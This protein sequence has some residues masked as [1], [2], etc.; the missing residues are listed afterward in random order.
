MAIWDRHEPLTV[1]GAAA[2]LH[3][4]PEHLRLK[5]RLQQYSPDG[6]CHDGCKTH[7]QEAKVFWFFFSKKN[8][9]LTK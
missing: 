5:E 2:A 3:R 9:F 1:A 6:K 8:C 7:F 4:I